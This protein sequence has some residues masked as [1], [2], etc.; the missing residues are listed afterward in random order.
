M[1]E[2]IQLA[3]T[4]NHR[5]VAPAALAANAWPKTFVLVPANSDES[6]VLD[7]VHSYLVGVATLLV[8]IALC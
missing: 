8:T 1:M 3:E 5:Q 2:F 6:V 7:V 4:T